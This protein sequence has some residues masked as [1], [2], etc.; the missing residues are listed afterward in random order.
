M[1]SLSEHQRTIQAAAAA[2]D[3]FAVNAVAGSG[4]T[5]CLTACASAID[6]EVLCLAFSKLD[7]ARL[8]TALERIPGAS[9][10]TTHAWGRRALVKAWGEAANANVVDVWRDVEIARKVVKEFPELRHM[11]RD[12]QA[13]ELVREWASKAKSATRYGETQ[14]LYDLVSPAA[15][16]MNERTMLGDAVDLALE[17]ARKD[18]GKASFDDL[19]YLPVAWQLDMP[20]SSASLLVDE[21]QD[22]SPCQHALIQHAGVPQLISVG[23]PSQAIYAWRGADRESMARMVAL[24]GGTTYPL[25]VSWRAPKAIRTLVH[26]FQFVEQFDCRPA[27]PEGVVHTIDVGEVLEHARAGDMIISRD[28]RN[29]SALVR[30]FI[31]AD[32]RVLVYSGMNDRARMLAKK[33]TKKLALELAGNY[34]A[35]CE[36]LIAQ[37]G[38]QDRRAQV[39]LDEWLALKDLVESFPTME[40]AARFM[41]DVFVPS[42]RDAHR[43]DA[44]ILSTVH[45]AKGAEAARVF[46]LHDTLYPEWGESNEERNCHY[47]SITRTQAELYIVLGKPADR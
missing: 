7:R 16:S 42:D 39:E 5:T 23:D 46:V 2:G 17:L 6:N 15:S 34:I 18:E 36:A 27:A 21:A 9:A 8:K 12:V 45:R 11:A 28:N 24:C 43:P 47:V 14:S 20:A 29:L 33:E 3:S 4:K 19:I 32:R 35:K 41:N 22:L 25:P 31:S 1:R 40:D 44:V 13:F 38:K 26:R 37:R 30:R 10:L